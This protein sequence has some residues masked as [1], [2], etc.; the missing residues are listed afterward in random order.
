MPQMTGS[1]ID[2]LAASPVLV[3]DMRAPPP[4]VVSHVLLVLLSALIIAPLMFLSL[5]VIAMLI[6]GEGHTAA[7]GKSEAGNSQNSG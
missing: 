2:L 4:L 1:P 3:P 5:S 6:L 7:E